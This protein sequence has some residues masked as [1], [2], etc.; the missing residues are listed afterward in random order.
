MN[1]G[2]LAKRTGVSSKTIRYYESIGV[3]PG[4]ERAANG[5]RSYGGEAEDR[6]Q[7]IRDARATGLSLTEIGSI[8]ELRD[9]GEATCEHVAELLAHH[10]IELD[11][12]IAALEA[13]REQLS[14]LA[15]R[16]G[17]LDPAACTD[18]NRC[19]TIMTSMEPLPGAAE[20]HRLGRQSSRASH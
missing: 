13:A 16:A 15:K 8:L 17:G 1:I 12:R 9:E 3:L 4:P 20:I 18:A 19:Q 11:Q 2:E 5:Y 6:L 10:V 7:F 14:E